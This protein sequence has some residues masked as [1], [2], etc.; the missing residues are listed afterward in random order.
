MKSLNTLST[1]YHHHLWANLVIFTRCCDLSDDQLDAAVPGVYGTIRETLNHIMRAERSY[2]SR[3]IS[4]NPSNQPQDT[5][6]LPIKEMRDEVEK[7][8][9]GL[10]DWAPKVKE[11]DSVLLDWDGKIRE[12]PKTIILNQVINHATE[13]RSQ[14]LSILTQIGIE[15]PDVSSWSYFEQGQD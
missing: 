15:P 3:I 10:I 2:L 6:D 13:H 9:Q 8:G 14:I 5:I 1:I 11:N 4:G 7:T 12:V